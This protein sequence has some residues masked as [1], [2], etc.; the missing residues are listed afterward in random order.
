MLRSQA[1][2]DEK[3]MI[4]HYQ[5][6]GYQRRSKNPT[7]DG[8]VNCLCTCVIAICLRHISTNKSEKPTHIIYL[9]ESKK[10]ALDICLV[11]TIMNEVP[12]Y[13]IYIYRQFCPMRI[14]YLIFM[15][16]WIYLMTISLELISTPPQTSCPS[17]ARSVYI[18]EWIKLTYIIYLIIE[19]E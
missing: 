1:S 7:R 11:N 6:S 9:P 13:I 14:S 5:T 10:T 19:I 18:I 4:D 16:L 3:L 8:F 17:Q 12:Y 2:P 15:V